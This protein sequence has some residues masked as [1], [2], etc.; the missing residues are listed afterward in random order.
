MRIWKVLMQGENIQQLKENMLGLL[1]THEGQSDANNSSEEINDSELIK[2]GGVFYDDLITSQL[3]KIESLVSTFD[4]SEKNYAHNIVIKALDY[5]I[6]DTILLNLDTDKHVE[7][8]KK[9]KD[10]KSILDLSSMSYLNQNALTNINET[11][12][13][14]ISKTLEDIKN[15]LPIENDTN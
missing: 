9:Y 2:I 4:E 8:F 1:R 10:I 3:P 14:V 11:I 7:F 5:A 12:T 15:Q 13:T 6:L